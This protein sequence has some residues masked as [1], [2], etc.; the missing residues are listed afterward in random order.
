[1]IGVSVAFMRNYAPE[2]LIQTSF[3]RDVRIDVP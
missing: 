1:M 2:S 3:N